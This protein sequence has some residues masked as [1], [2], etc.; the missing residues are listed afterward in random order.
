VCVCVRWGGGLLDNFRLSK[1]VALTGAHGHAMT[2]AVSRRPLTAEA[3]VRARV[4]PCGI[5]GGHVVLGQAF[6]LVLR[7]Y[8]SISFHRGSPYSY[9]T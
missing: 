6:L 3:S 5:C 2:Q 1:L 4:S 9:I 7:F 8:L